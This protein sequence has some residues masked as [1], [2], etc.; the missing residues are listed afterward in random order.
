MERYCNSSWSQ[1]VQLLRSNAET[2]MSE[3][4]CELRKRRKGIN[5]IDLPDKV[6]IHKNIFE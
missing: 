2:G 3:K 6:R 1:I 5:K 4:D